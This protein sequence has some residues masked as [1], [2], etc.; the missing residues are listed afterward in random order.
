MDL[1][2]AVMLFSGERGGG[3]AFKER[4]GAPASHSA[5]SRSR[6]ACANLAESSEEG[7]YQ[8]Q[9]LFW[10]QG[11]VQ[12]HLRGM[13]QLQRYSRTD[14]CI[15]LSNKMELFM[16]CKLEVGWEMNRNFTCGLLIIHLTFLVCL[17]KLNRKCSIVLFSHS[18]M[19]SDFE[20]QCIIKWSGFLL[21]FVLTWNGEVNWKCKAVFTLCQDLNRQ[22][23]FCNGTFCFVVF[24]SFIID[25]CITGTDKC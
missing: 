8:V 5:L 2:S 23:Y 24:I 19:L 18:V 20:I 12:P 17:T 13:H 22:F 3:R 4:A 16:K 10:A 7:H 6:S 9:A 11:A 25:D 14:G 15:D 21:Q 1:T